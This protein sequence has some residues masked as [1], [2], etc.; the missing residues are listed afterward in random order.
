MYK[1]HRDR[2]RLLVTFA[3]KVAVR[4]YVAAVAPE[5][6]LVPLL[7]TTRD[8]RTLD[9]S[10]LP[11]QFV[12]K[13]SHASGGVLLVAE[14]APA[15]RP[16]PTPADGLVRTAVHPDRLDWRQLCATTDAWLRTPYTGP[17]GEWAYSQVEPT[18]LV[19]ELLAGA[20]GRA[21]T[22]YKLLVFH[23]RC[24]AVEVAAGRF[25]DY[26]ELTFTPAWELIED[27]PDDRRLAEGVLPPDSLPA[28]VAI[29]ERL[30]AE[31]DFVRVD[32]YEVDGRV[33][34][35]ELTNYPGGGHAMNTRRADELLGSFWAVP[36]RYC[37]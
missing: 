10:T 17:L 14:W 9:P 29:A 6:E 18:L 5:C 8:V 24:R 4:G 32:L 35:G 23:G 16:T 31:T 11:R 12:V 37:D 7:A 26:C 19:E 20:D 33:V 1:I 34:F 21:P 36:P 25:G 13:A 22:D 3:D 30:G 27:G 28:M 2:R 15:G